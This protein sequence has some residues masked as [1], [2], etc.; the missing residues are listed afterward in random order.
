MKTI[1]TYLMEAERYAVQ[2]A[3]FPTLQAFIQKENIFYA[4]DLLTAKEQQVCDS[5]TD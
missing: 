3:L 1:V 2:E 4:D 5:A